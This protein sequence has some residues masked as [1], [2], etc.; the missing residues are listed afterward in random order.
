MI[1]RVVFITIIVIIFSSN[2]SCFK[3]KSINSSRGGSCSSENLCCPGRDAS[4]VIH[5]SVKVNLFTS[6]HARMN[7]QVK[8]Q[9]HPSQMEASGEANNDSIQDNNVN[10]DDDDDDDDDNTIETEVDRTCYCDSACTS[11]GDCCHD[12]EKT[13]GGKLSLNFYSCLFRSFFCVCLSSL[14]HYCLVGDVSHHKT[15]QHTQLYV[16][17]IDLRV[18]C[19]LFPVTC[20]SLHQTSELVQ[21]KKNNKCEEERKKGK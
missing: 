9:V 3:R 17:L 8:H 15:H 16:F 2:S 11:V 13:C 20:T 19:S 10:D 4:C 5:S 1:S 7:E 14:S 21:L 6:N 18:V 12:Y